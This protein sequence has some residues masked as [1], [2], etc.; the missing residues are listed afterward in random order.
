MKRF[1]FALLAFCL[2]LQPPLGAKSVPLSDEQLLE[3]IQKQS[4]GFFAREPSRRTGLVADRASNLSQGMIS[5]PASIAATGFGLS[6]L[7][8]A[9]KNGWVEPA[10]ARGLARRT[11]LFFLENAPEEH[12]FF[13]HFLNKET[14][15][16]VKNSELSPIDTALFLAGALFIAD[17]FDDPDLR[18]LAVKIYER[19]DFPWMLNG[20]EHLA[21]AWSPEQGFSKYRWDHFDESLLLY[22]LA[23]GSPTHPIDPQSWKTLRRPAG[24]Y[25]EMHIIQMPPLFTHQYPHLW[26]DFR[27]KNDGF[28]D[29]FQNSVNA[30]KIQRIFAIDQAKNFPAYGPDA[31][32]IT[33]SDGPYGYKAYGAPPGW[34][35]HDGTLAPTGCGSSMMF[36]PEASMACLR[37]YYEKYHERLWGRYGFSDAFNLDQDWFSDQVIG[38]DQGALILAIENYRSGLLWKTLAQNP[39]LVD[40]M[41]HAGFKPGTLALPWP[42]P[43]EYKAPH[44]PGGITVD[45]YLR[46]WPGTA[47]VIKIK[48]GL[49]ESGEEAEPAD[50]DGEIRIAWDEN[51]LYFAVRV[52]DQDI[53]SRRVGKHI[54]MDDVVELYADPAGDGLRWKDAADFQIGFS[55]DAASAGSVRVWSWFQQGLDPVETGDV[56]ARS[57]IYKGGYLIEAAV[58]WSYLGMRPAAGAALDLSFSL[59]DVDRDRTE[60]KWQWFMRSEKENLRFELGHFKLSG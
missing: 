54:W 9:E 37:H 21:L 4:Y 28:A 13:Y 20:G 33:A 8:V 34:A 40:G 51:A 30:S 25:G 43:P 23:L 42:A 14:G 22:I 53:I 5:A 2:C 60:S 10:Y 32:G 19:I 55:P 18:N 16:R 47:P 50:L 41:M 26:I 57:S 1:F 31:W 56:A 46:D 17:Y 36:T 7:G 58:R 12:G 39:F 59:H 11:L 29:Y 3:L 6:A 49:F 24:S 48:D 52:T 15:E 44:I 27:D 38:I 35:Q 45:G